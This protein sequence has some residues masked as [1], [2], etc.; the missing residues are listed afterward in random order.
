[1]FDELKFN[2]SLVVSNHYLTF[3]KYTYLAY[4]FITKHFKYIKKYKK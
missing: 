3:D 4:I 1:M 2:P